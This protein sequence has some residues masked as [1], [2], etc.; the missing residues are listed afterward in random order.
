MKLRYI[1]N[2]DEQTNVDATA[3]NMGIK[4]TVSKIT[5]RFMWAGVIKMLKTLYVA[6]YSLLRPH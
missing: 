1:V 2:K 4:K 3:G 6:C 5:E